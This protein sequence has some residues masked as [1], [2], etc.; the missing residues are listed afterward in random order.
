MHTKA[1]F[2][3][4]IESVAQSGVCEVKSAVVVA[5]VGEM[6]TTDVSCRDW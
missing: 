4:D 6:T 1:S 3:I 2:R 5:S